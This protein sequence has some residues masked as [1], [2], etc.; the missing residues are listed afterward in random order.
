[1]IKWR[2][3]V[4]L[5]VTYITVGKPVHRR[6]TNINI[7][8]Y[9]YMYTVFFMPVHMLVYEWYRFKCNLP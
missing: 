9:I 7:S 2:G 3:Q 6:H 8:I 1:M 4:H 5:L